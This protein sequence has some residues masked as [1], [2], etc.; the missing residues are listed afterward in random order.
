MGH[1]ALDSEPVERW[2]QDI[3]T[4]VLDMMGHDGQVPLLVEEVQENLDLALG[5]D[6]GSFLYENAPRKLVGFDSFSRHVEQGVEVLIV[7][8]HLLPILVSQRG[9]LN[10]LVVL[11]AARLRVEDVE[12]L[13]VD[14]LLFLLPLAPEILLHI[15]MLLRQLG[16][17]QEGLTA[18]DPLDNARGL[19]LSSHEGLLRLLYLELLLPL[20]FYLLILCIFE[21]SL[22]SVNF[23]FFSL[24][25]FL[26]LQ[27]LLQ[28]SLIHV[29][30]LAALELLFFGLGS[31]GVLLD[32]D[33]VALELLERR[34]GL[35][36]RLQLVSVP[37]LVFSE[38]LERR[39]PL[40]LQ[41]IVDRRRGCLDRFA[42]LS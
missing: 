9:N 17:G 6:L 10:R 24:H 8:G 21:D 7:L 25:I 23:L 18:F 26:L 39:H 36:Y 33:A 34:S 29:I 38:S 3:V 4:V 30:H 40:G 22:Y 28:S 32:L 35:G 19:Q 13:L 15:L 12:A 11:E 37:F 16:A 20:N 27:L 41:S 2:L 5:D 14:L 31:F 42:H 1:P